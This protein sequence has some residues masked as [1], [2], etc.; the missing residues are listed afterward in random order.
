[1]KPY[2]E[3]KGQKYEFEGN[4]NL[5]R[6]FD[7]EIQQRYKDMYK[8]GDI[9]EQDLKEIQIIEKY[10]KENPNIDEET[11]S[12]DEEMSKRIMKY[13]PMMDSLILT[14]IYEKYCFKMLES[15]Y[16][17]NKEQWNEM[18]E[19]Y[20]EDYCETTEEI[21]ILFNKVIEKVFIQKGEKKKKSL[22]TW[23]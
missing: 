20:F 2:I 13:A 7:K 22:P 9:T 1:M 19:Q 11:L 4:F 12:N 18:L 8:N 10:I 6:E 14:D 5:R 15:K 23:M 16:S 3:Y 17:I 21:D